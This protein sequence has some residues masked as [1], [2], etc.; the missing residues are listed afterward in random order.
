VPLRT[1]GRARLAEAV[2]GFIFDEEARLEEGNRHPLVREHPETGTKA[3]Y[4]HAVKVDHIE[5]LTPDET[6]DV[7]VDILDRLDHS[8][9]LYKHQ[10]RKNDILI[11]DN[12]SALHQAY[13]DYEE[14]DIRLL[15]K[16]ILKGT[17]PFGPAMPK[18][19]FESEAPATH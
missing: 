18:S 4:F 10:W 2:K 5:G 7:L 19:E 6:R 11:W 3:I 13:F 14:T 8:K 1:G 16:V 17:R 15:H 12:R 9:F